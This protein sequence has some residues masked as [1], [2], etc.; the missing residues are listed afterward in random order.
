MTGQVAAQTS[1]ILHPLWTTIDQ[2]ELL[3]NV[4]CGWAHYK[5]CQRVLIIQHL[6]RQYW[7][8]PRSFF[9]VFCLNL[10]LDKVITRICKDLQNK[11]CWG[12]EMWL[13]RKQYCI[14]IKDLFWSCIKAS[15]VIKQT[16]NMEC[17]MDC[18]WGKH[19]VKFQVFHMLSKIKFVNCFDS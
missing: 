5:S 10:V 14:A 2:L 4:K 18:G 19:E 17:L 13:R 9:P 12:L 3:A 6:V 15:P 1:F 11:V 8:W 16:R 7:K